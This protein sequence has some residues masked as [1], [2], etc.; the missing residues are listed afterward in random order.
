MKGATRLG[1]VLALSL[2]STWVC[3]ADVADS[4]DLAQLP[5][6][7]RA[8]LVDYRQ[9]SDLERVFPAAS[10]RRINGRLR[11]EAQVASLG[12]LTAL[13]YKLPVEHSASEAFT[14]AREHLQ[15][16]GAQLLFWCQGRDC[17]ASSL[18][19]NNVFANAQL[20]GGDDQQAYALL[21]LAAPQQDT[22]LALYGITRG[23]RRA[24]LH[25]ELLN[26]SAPLGEL[27]PSAATLLLQLKSAGE[28]VFAQEPTVQ[29]VT[30]LAN[31][32]KMDSSLSIS[33]SGP[34][35]LAWQAALSAQG[36]RA[37][38]LQVID[39]ANSG[40]LLKVLRN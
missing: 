20:N 11:M 23:N 29:R 32:L 37:S 22:L 4:Q 7:A 3:A 14:A 30:V 5:R 10:L 35:A 40:L 16:E 24:Y 36:V 9:S 1:G 21:R 27:L 25:V 8:E 15:A 6:F 12:D 2:A 39:N 34:Q 33:L 31:S 38:R 13:T 19:A 28:L 26:A 18:W 17:G